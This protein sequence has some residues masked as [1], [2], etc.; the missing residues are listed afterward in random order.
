MSSTSPA[1]QAGPPAAAPRSAGGVAMSSKVPPTARPLRSHPLP[2]EPQTPPASTQPLTLLSYDKG[3]GSEMTARP[4]RAEPEG[5][6]FAS[7]L[8]ELGDGNWGEA[9][10]LVVA[11]E[12]EDAMVAPP[13]LPPLAAAPDPGPFPFPGAGVPVDEGGSPPRITAAAPQY[14]KVNL[15]RIWDVGLRPDLY[16]PEDH[17]LYFEWLRDQG[18]RPSRS[19]PQ[20]R[21]YLRTFPRNL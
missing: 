6:G 13:P 5:H 11:G 18:L 4:T 19:C 9:E 20:Y 17:V 7:P 8:P 10:Q 1:R 2:A 3:W 15:S 21:L 12:D 16:A 14:R